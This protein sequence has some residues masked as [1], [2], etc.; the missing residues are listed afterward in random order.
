MQLFILLCPPLNER[1]E[2]SVFFIQGEVK[3]TR[4][5]DLMIMKLLTGIKHVRIY[6]EVNI[7]EILYIL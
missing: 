2:H 4:L 7:T 1:N 3:G 6:L 5:H